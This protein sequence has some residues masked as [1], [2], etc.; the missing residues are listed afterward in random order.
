[1]GTAYLKVKLCLGL[2]FF[3]ENL[4]LAEFRFQDLKGV[5][6]YQTYIALKMHLDGEAFL[7]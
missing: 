5:C 2:C 1:M 7:Y 6:F 4:A 3:A